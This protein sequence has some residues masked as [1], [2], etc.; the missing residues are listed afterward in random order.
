[1]TSSLRDKHMHLSDL[2]NTRVVLTQDLSALQEAKERVSA[3]T[4][5]ICH[6]LEYFGGSQL[7]KPVILWL[8]QPMQSNFILHK[9]GIRASVSTQ[10]LYLHK[11]RNY[12]KQRITCL[13]VYT[14]K[15]FAQDINNCGQG[16]KVPKRSWGGGWGG[17][18]YK[19][20]FI[21]ICCLQHR[22]SNTVQFVELF[23]T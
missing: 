10:T 1:M 19:C 17:S 3:S 20:T 16:L 18:V 13:N 4:N 23:Q 15:T 8:N 2:Q 7:Y 14:M 11:N 12:R 21:I 9:R 6:T 22:N 5:S